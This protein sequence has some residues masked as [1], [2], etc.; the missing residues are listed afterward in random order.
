MIKRISLIVP[1]LI[2]LALF[3]TSC[4]NEA[5]LGFQATSTKTDVDIRSI[6]E[7]DVVTFLIFSPKGIGDADISLSSG[8][9]PGTVQVRLFVNGLDNLALTYDSVRIT[10]SVPNSGGPVMERV[11][12]DG[13]ETEIDA[14]SPYWMDIQLLP[15]EPG[16]LFIGEPMLPASFL[17]TLPADFHRTG[18][19]QFFLDWVDFYR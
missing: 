14:T 18:A 4:R 5:A 1:T 7:D 16:G 8:K 13:A 11:F 15:E 9:M 19:E 3:L 10:A 6:Y 17:I 2:F 12:K